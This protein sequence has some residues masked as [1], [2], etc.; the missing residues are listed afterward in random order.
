MNALYTSLFFLIKIPIFIEKIINN[1]CL[2]INLKPSCYE[3]KE[4]DI[5]FKVEERK[6]MVFTINV[7]QEVKDTDPKQ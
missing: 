1:Y 2:R 6:R 5:S 7:P 4:E 3:P